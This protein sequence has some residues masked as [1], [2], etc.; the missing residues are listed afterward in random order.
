VAAETVRARAGV[1]NEI[2]RMAE[3]AHS[4]QA[5]AGPRP[6][7]TAPDGNQVACLSQLR[8]V[9]AATNED[10]W[11]VIALSSNGIDRTRYLIVKGTAHEWVD[12]DTVWVP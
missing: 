6:T 1:A 9:R 7:A 4:R 10:G 8:V 3:L 11:R 2:I 12:A 5:L